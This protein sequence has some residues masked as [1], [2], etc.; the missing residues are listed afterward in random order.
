MATPF[1]M[2]TQ[3]G[4]LWN[5]S[6][7]SP[8]NVHWPDVAAALAKACRFG[9]HVQAGH[10]SVAQHCCVVCDALPPDMRLY[11]LLHDAHEAY[12]GDW[13]RPLK[14]LFAVHLCDDDI[15]LMNRTFMRHARAVTT[16]AG[17]A[18]PRGEA[19]QQRVAEANQRALATE[20]R[21]L[22]A[23]ARQPVD[24]PQADPFPARI[25]PW[26]WARAADEWLTRLEQYGTYTRG[27]ET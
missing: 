2:Q 21:D 4:R 5:L 11:G 27:T 20:R 19:V 14:L 23:P 22:L 15:S 17:L 3:S 24:W 9:G 10:Y 13:M 26:P 12:L 6:E 1:T 7:P 8:D 25:K 16:A 18:W